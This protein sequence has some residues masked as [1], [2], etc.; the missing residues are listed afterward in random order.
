MNLF[1]IVA[2]QDELIDQYIDSNII[3]TTY[4]SCGNSL[5]M[6][7]VMANN[8]FSVYDLININKSKNFLYYANKDGDTAFS[9]AIVNKYYDIIDM[10]LFAKINILEDYILDC[11]DIILPDKQIMDLLHSYNYFFCHSHSAFFLDKSESGCQTCITCNR[12]ICGCSMNTCKNINCCI[13]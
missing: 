3:D 5:L 12:T 8:I 1:E 7:A 9:L 2:H 11:H 13:I 10:L 6:A 4:D